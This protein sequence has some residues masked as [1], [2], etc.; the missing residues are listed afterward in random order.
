MALNTF[1]GV[2][3]AIRRLTAKARAV[4]APAERTAAEARLAGLHE[5]NLAATSTLDLHTVLKVLLEK[6]DLLLPYSAATVRLFNKESGM[7]EQ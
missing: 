4:G 7:H 3:S 5:I 1:L 6:I 2:G